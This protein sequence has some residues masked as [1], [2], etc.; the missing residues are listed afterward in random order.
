[1]NINDFKVG[2][3]FNYKDSD[4]T[5]ELIC[6]E[7]HDGYILAQDISHP[8]FDYYI[9]TEGLNGCHKPDDMSEILEAYNRYRE[10]ELHTAPL[11]EISSGESLVLGYEYFEDGWSGTYL[12]CDAF[13]RCD[14]ECIEYCINGDVVITKNY[15]HEEFVELIDNSDRWDFLD[16]LIDMCYE[17]IKARKRKLAN[18]VHDVRRAFEDALNDV[19]NDMI[20]ALVDTNKVVALDRVIEGL[21]ELRKLEVGRDDRYEA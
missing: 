5:I 6:T 11:H 3:R 15:T 20:D 13:Y 18:I 16:E 1:M 19:Q 12:E 9:S 21:N 2:T 14:K 10:R 4:S 7:V 8:L 17:N